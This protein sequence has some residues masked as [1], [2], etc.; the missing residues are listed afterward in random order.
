MREIFNPRNP[1]PNQ[2]ASKAALRGAIC[3]FISERKEVTHSELVKLF[4]DYQLEEALKGLFDRQYLNLV[5]GKYSLNPDP[6]RRRPR[7]W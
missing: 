4:G 6:P 2:L 3:G 1:P 5:G 7:S